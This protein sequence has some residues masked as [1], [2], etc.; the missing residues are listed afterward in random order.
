MGAILEV[1]GG[2]LA[3]AAER[4]EHDQVNL[5]AARDAAMRRLDSLEGEM[6]A[7]SRLHEGV[8][9]SG[10][11]GSGSGGGGGGGGRVGGGPSGGVG[12][13]TAAAATGGAARRGH[14]QKRRRREGGHAVYGGADAEEEDDAGGGSGYGKAESHED[15]RESEDEEDE[16]EEEDEDE[17]DEADDDES[18]DELPIGRLLGRSVREPN[19]P[20]LDG[21]RRR[22]RTSSLSA[23]MVGRGASYKLV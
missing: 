7:L 8:D 12:T 13:G 5:R 23:A 3:A 21:K 14:L 2:A 15:A 1:A 19:P 10:G 16:E 6:L 17:D 18:G 9:G 20:S 4:L 11:G 22:P